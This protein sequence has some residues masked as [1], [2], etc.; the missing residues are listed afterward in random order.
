MAN[1]SEKKVKKDR[2]LGMIDTLIGGLLLLGFLGLI[3]GIILLVWVDWNWDLIRKVMKTS[4]F[5]VGLGIAIGLGRA[6]WSV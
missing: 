3:V 1:I 4:L 6:V 5:L 2:A